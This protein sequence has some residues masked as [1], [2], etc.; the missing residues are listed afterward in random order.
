VD[1]NKDGGR[2]EVDGPGIES[3]ELKEEEVKSARKVYSIGGSTSGGISAVRDDI[4][5]IIVGEDAHRRRRRRHHHP[6][7]RTPSH[8]RGWEALRS[9]GEANKK[10]S[11]AIYSCHWE[12]LERRQVFGE[13]QP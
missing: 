1:A 11:K 10:K 3:V 8:V 5:Y 4:I 7:H 6:R 12:G 9:G 13:R 2:A